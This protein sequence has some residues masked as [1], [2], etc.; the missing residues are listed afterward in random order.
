MPNIELYIYGGLAF[1]AGLLGGLFLIRPPRPLNIEDYQ[2]KAEA[3]LN[4]FN[5][6]VQ[7]IHQDALIRVEN[8]KN[9]SREDE[10]RSRDQVKR[11]ENLLASREEN[12]KNK[13]QKISELKTVMDYEAGLVNDLKN[14]TQEFRKESLQRLCQKAGHTMEDFRESLMNETRSDLEREREEKIRK[15]EEYL[16][17]NKVRLAQNIIVGALQRYSSPTS[18][19]KKATIIEVQKD[20]FKYR[21]LGK[22]CEILLLLEELLGVDIILNDA[23]GTIII[24]YYDLVKKHIASETIRKLLM[25]KIVTPDKV[26]EKIKDAERETDQHLLRIG[27][28]TAKNLGLANRNLPPEFYKIV[29]RLQFRTSYGQNILKHSI[30]VGN[31]TLMLGGELG[32]NLQTCKIGG[33][34]HDLG[35][36]IDQEVNSPHDVLTKEIMEKYGFSEEEIHAAWTHHDSIPLRTAEAM[37][38]KAGD[39]ISAGRPG[40]RQE[41]IEK[42]LERIRAL[43]NIA[44]SYEGVNKAFAISAGREVRVLVEPGELV[45]SD[46]NDLARSIADDIQDNVGYPGKIKINVIRRTT[47]VDYAKR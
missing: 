3:V 6:E 18:V 30:E 29:G 34:F 24:S 20:E 7:R 11:M 13:T 45:D 33:F 46:L 37:L 5:Q 15:Y 16:Q 26:R 4:S 19:E 28:E 12:V 25:E 23:P 36:A 21:I 41:S 22:N 40:A 17:D 8:I 44:N 39:A 10:E 35:K 42:Y 2:K 47:A 1:V 14:K 43:E 32:L 38:V 31:F 9:R 27:R